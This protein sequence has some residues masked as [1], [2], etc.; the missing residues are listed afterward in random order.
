DVLAQIVNF[1]GALG[2]STG[3][4]YCFSDV[5]DPTVTTDCPCGNFGNPGS[6]CANSNAT[7]GGAR[8]SAAGTTVPNTVVFTGTGIP[9]NN[10]CT[11]L[12]GTITTSTGFAFGDGVR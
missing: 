2:N 8:L 3:E 1:D 7:L 9:N 10:L 4:A 11:F 5:I 6:G 12:R